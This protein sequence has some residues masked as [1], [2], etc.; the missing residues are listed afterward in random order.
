[1]S[2][3]ARVEFANGESPKLGLTWKSLVA[4]F[5]SGS[6]AKSVE[7]HGVRRCSRRNGP[8]VVLPSRDL[9]FRH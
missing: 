7:R 6:Q 4:A 1:M 3:T 2:R 8:A 9:L 5:T